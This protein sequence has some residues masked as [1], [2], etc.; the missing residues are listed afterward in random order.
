MAR[1]KTRDAGYELTISILDTKPAIWR[2]VE[3]SSK[4]TL[5]RLHDVLQIAFGWQDMHLHNFTVGEALYGSIGGD[6][7]EAWERKPIDE[8]K[9]TVRDL[10]LRVGQVFQ[11]LYDYGD[12]WEHEVVVSRVLDIAPLKPRCVDGERAAAPEDCGGAWGHVEMLKAMKAKR[13]TAAQKEK[14]EWLGDGYEP[15]VFFVGEINATLR[16]RF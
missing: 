11:Y 13:K 3:V 1:T 4:L 2:R 8:R 14:L 16:R 10:N 12:E 6:P 7:W 9:V 15:D 5:E